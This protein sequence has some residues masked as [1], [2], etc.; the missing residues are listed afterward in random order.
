MKA[1]RKTSLSR[2]LLKK[3]TIL[4]FILA[5]LLITLFFSRTNLS[6]ILYYLKRVDPIF[7]GLAFVSHYATYLVRADRWKRMLRQAGFS[8]HLLDLAKIIFVFQSI[9]CVI[10]AKIGD[11]YGAHLMRTNFSM[12]RSYSFG[13]IFLWRI[14]DLVIVVAVAGI[15]AAA[16][17]GSGL[18]HELTVLLKI[19]VPCLAALVA[20]LLLFFRFHH[21]LAF[22]L[23]SDRLKIWVDSF[24]EGLRMNW[25]IMPALLFGTTL[26]W[27][28]EAG[29]FYFVCK[30]MHVA[31]DWIAVLFVTSLATLLTA[32]PLTPSGLGAVELGMLKLLSL[33]RIADPAAYPLIIWDRFI[34]H[35]SQII[36]GVLFIIFNRRI[37][38]DIVPKRNLNLAG[39]EKKIEGILD[40]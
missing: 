12:S 15:T 34:A 11:I 18:P 33:V 28:L 2:E 26:I 1:N 37:N 3:R 7:V 31:T 9:D 22:R 19:A 36:L 25:R 40:A 38:L 17:F 24:R 29:R 23:K 10:P 5:L 30:S 4:S 32:F 27:F 16:L 20:L 21:H 14:L 13:T 35:W 39:T 8:G 6:E